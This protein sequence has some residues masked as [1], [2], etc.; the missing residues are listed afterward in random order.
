MVGSCVTTMNMKNVGSCVNIIHFFYL[1]SYGWF[2]CNNHEYDKCWFL[3]KQHSF[4]FMAAIH[5]IWKYTCTR[6]D[7][8]S[9][10]IRNHFLHVYES[11][12]KWNQIVIKCILEETCW[13]MVNEM[14]VCV[15]VNE[16]TSPPP[17]EYVLSLWKL[18]R[19]CNMA[20]EF[21]KFIH[22]LAFKELH[23]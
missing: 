9:M 8:P 13:S 19:E 11:C 16:Y 20:R 2:L 17:T 15:N 10:Y 12:K 14:M 7:K 22:F 6:N 1:F 18:L 23:G 21:S 4:V 5:K 3:C